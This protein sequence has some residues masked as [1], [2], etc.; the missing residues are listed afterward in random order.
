[1]LGELTVSLAHEINQP[2]AAA[3]TSAGACLRWLDREQPELE[4]AREAIKRIKDDGKRAAEIISRLKAFYKKESSHSES[5]SM[6]MK[7]SARCSY[8]CVERPTDTR[9]PCG[10]S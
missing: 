7:S 1:M 5:C 4:R 9:S 2:I 6:S 10:R 8:C 3:I